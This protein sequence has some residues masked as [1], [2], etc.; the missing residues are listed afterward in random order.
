M[1]RCSKKEESVLMKRT[2]L[3]QQRKCVIKTNNNGDI[4]GQQHAQQLDLLG[5]VY[6]EAPQ[7]VWQSAATRALEVNA[8]L[9][10]AVVGE[11]R[12]AE[13][14]CNSIDRDDGDVEMDTDDDDEREAVDDSNDFDKS[15][16]SDEEEDKDVDDEDDD[17][18]DDEDE[19]DEKDSECEKAARGRSRL[20]ASRR[21]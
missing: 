13:Q 2:G 12:R 3:G 10:A 19:K 15:E 18:E 1:S 17:E 4:V 11:Q 21:K 9:M 8:L 20:P 14:D 6:N 7:A 16:S 5:S